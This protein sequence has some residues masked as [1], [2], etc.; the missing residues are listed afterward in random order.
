[1]SLK[2]RHI[3]ENRMTAQDQIDKWVMEATSSYNDGWTQKHY[4]DLLQEV[5][6][7][8]NQLEFIL[9]DKNGKE[10]N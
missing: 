5:Y 3:V 4:R 10:S 2:E 7:R 8:L 9:K 1:M 6:D